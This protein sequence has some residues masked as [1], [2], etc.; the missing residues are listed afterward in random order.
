MMDLIRKTVASPFGFQIGDHCQTLYTEIGG[1]GTLKG[2]YITDK[3]I[4]S[5]FAQEKDSYNAC[6]AAM[7]EKF[8]KLP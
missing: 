4:S 1:V 8:A 2:M 6:M 5:T 3:S 7:L